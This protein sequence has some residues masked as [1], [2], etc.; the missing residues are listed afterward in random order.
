MTERRHRRDSEPVSQLGPDW[1]SPTKLYER[2]ST[3]LSVPP[4]IYGGTPLVDYKCKLCTLASDLTASTSGKDKS[5]GISASQAAHAEERT[6]RMIVDDW[7]PEEIARAVSGAYGLKISPTAI[8][9]HKKEHIFSP[10]AYQ[11]QRLREMPI[12]DY[13]DHAWRAIFDLLVS[14]VEGARQG[15]AAGRLTPNL[16]E[17]LAAAK[18]L[19]ELLSYSLAST[20]ASGGPGSEQDDLEEARKR[21]DSM[22]MFVAVLESVVERN[23]K[24]ETERQAI[25]AAT[26]EVLEEQT[27]RRVSQEGA[28]GEELPRGR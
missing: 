12:D 2:T 5:G 11:A 4:L 23:V 8:K 7:E 15:V 9:R 13:N 22:R 17:G 18:T 20:S 26:Q 3:D 27:G 19:S 24:S 16:T 10:K 21:E 14:T 1:P 28:D 6:L 25:Y